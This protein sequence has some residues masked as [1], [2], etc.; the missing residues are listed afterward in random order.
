MILLMTQLMP[1]QI[2]E[3]KCYKCGLAQKYS[4]VGVKIKA[5]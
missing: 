3:F 5:S 2:I 4:N 1:E